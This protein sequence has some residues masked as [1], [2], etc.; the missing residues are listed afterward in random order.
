MPLNEVEKEPKV[1]WKAD[2]NTYYTIMMTDADSS[3]NDPFQ[4][5]FLHWLVLNVP[6]TDISKGEIKA[7]YI[8]PAAGQRN[9]IN[10]KKTAHHFNLI[11]VNF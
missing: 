10:F 7:P 3:P 2:K 9:L 4:R 5:E 11:L 8:P 1:I 6:G